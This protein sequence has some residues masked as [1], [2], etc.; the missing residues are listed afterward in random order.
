MTYLLYWKD[1]ASAVS[2]GWRVKESA[3]HTCAFLFGWVGA[4][5]GQHKL[6]HK[7]QKQS[8]RL[9]FWVTVLFN[10][11]C[12]GWLHTDSGGQFLRTSIHGIEGFVWRFDS[13]SSAM[14]W[15]LE[16]TKFQNWF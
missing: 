16:L 15:F 3:L 14:P 6:R 13:L 9:I 12:I 5:V 2:G 8:F 1:K 7:T 4:I 10:V 11:V